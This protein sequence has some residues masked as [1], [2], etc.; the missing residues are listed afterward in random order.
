[1]RSTFFLPGC[2]GF[3]R[4]PHDGVCGATERVCVR[5]VGMRDWQGG[6]SR[7]LRAGEGWPLARALR[8]DL[9]LTSRRE[10][11]EAGGGA[12]ESGAHSYHMSTEQNDCG[13]LES[14]ATSAGERSKL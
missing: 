3:V 7:A 8:K 11:G 2:S 4:F 12:A 6:H 1:M 9:Q 14:S 13:R 5:L 10:K